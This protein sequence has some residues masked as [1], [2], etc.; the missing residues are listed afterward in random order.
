MGIPREFTGCTVDAFHQLLT[1]SAKILKNILDWCSD[2]G[3]MNFI[4]RKPRIETTG[5]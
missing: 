1:L 2:S 5:Q 4:H 3:K